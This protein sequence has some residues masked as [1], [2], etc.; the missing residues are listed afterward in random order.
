[1]RSLLFAS[2]A[3][4]ALS[5]APAFGA[6][7]PL[8]V[9]T[10][11]AP[12]TAMYNWTG[13]YVG[14]NVGYSVGRDPGSESNPGS[15]IADHVTLG[16]HGALGGFQAGYNWQSGNLLLGI[17]G[18]WQWTGQKDSFCF[19]ATSCGVLGTRGG[20]HEL[21]WFATVRGRLGYA[22]GPTLFYATGGVAFAQVKQV[23]AAGTEVASFSNSK[24]GWTLG[25][26]IEAALGGNWTAKVEYLH[27]DLGSISG[28]LPNFTASSDVRDNVARVGLNYRFA[29]G[30]G[31]GTP[32]I[33]AYN[34]TGFYLGANA[35][36]SIGHDA[37]LQ[38]VGG[39]LEALTITPAGG[40]F[41]G[42]LGYNWQSGNWVV[43]VEGDGQW[44]GQ[45]D[46]LCRLCPSV[47]G[48]LTQFIGNEVT[49][50]A[51]VRGRLGFAA[52]PVLFY[53]TGG[54]VFA[55]VKLNV[56]NTIPAAGTSAISVSS[57][58][59]GWTLG[60]GIEAALGGNWTAKVEY[61]YFDLGSISASVPP[62][63]TSFV[64]SEVRDHVVRFGLNYRFG[65][66]G[67]PLAARY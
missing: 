13:F 67:W 44:A 63:V 6:D 35:G 27:I 38:N 1:M 60:G 48:F 18:D 39:L 45:K 14:G 37:T 23:I 11:K 28:T 47:P 49:S 9:P 54:A 26:G 24:T 15:P 59:T 65:D 56:L 40:L 61:L 5:C 16:P 22:V 12:L 3:A 29:G 51:T 58:R 50:F 43:G 57:E 34:W 10:Y 53:G 25:G 64:T 32:V 19:N 36:Y 8:K 41:G 42:Q 46:Q 66:P 2:A 30:G 33:A 20:E 31:M 55:N 7:M 62:P 52:G 17:E 4:A 21:P